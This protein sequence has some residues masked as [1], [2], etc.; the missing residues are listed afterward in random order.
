MARG[1]N[2][3]LKGLKVEVDEAS[4]KEVAEEAIKK[5]L[6][7][8]LNTLDLENGS[9]VD[10]FETVKQIANILGMQESKK[11]IAQY[12]T[13]L[14]QSGRYQFDID[15]KGN[16]RANYNMI[17]M[18]QRE[19][20][21]KGKEEAERILKGFIEKVEIQVNEMQQRKEIITDASIM[22]KFSEKERIINRE[23]IDLAI[24]H[25]LETQNQ[26]R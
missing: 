23:W 2:E 8:I 9:T 16:I 14:F 4:Q 3:F 22:S 6:F 5:Q 20:D 18:I 10:L 12:I 17:Y 21:K 19:S 26:E 11:Q 24:D 15:E 25:V 1:Q 7:R 13:Q